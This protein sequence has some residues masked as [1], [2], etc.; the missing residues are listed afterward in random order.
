MDSRC[1]ESI[2][3]LRK[4][5]LCELPE[6]AGYEKMLASKDGAEAIELLNWACQE[7]SDMKMNWRSVYDKWSGETDFADELR[8][9]RKEKQ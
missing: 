1:T 3:I 7:N 8:A 4:I 6:P 5:W 2:A 9:A